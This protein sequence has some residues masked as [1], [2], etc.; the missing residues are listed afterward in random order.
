M[1]KTQL[2]R[3]GIND[4]RVLAALAEVPREQFVD[5]ALEQNAYGDHALPIDCGQTI[6]QPY[7]VAFMCQAAEIQ[8]SDRV[9]EVGTGSGYGAAVLGQLAS[10]VHS[11]ERHPTL[12]SSARERLQR[13]GYSHVTVHVGDGTLGLAEHAPFDAIIVTAA[14]P[15]LPQSLARQLREGGRLVMPVGESPRAQEMVRFVRHNGDLLESR[16][17]QFAFVPL[18]GE[19]A[20]KVPKEG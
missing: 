8:P 11:I 9:L 5:A 17:G 4:R 16:L 13:C 14:G 1:V 18:I 3:R 12:A 7:T 2:A 6:S 15:R 10:E 19:E 20:W